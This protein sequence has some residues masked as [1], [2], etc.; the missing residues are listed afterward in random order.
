MVNKKIDKTIFLLLMRIIMFWVLCINISIA[1]IST[2]FH[3][4]GHAYMAWS[5]GDNSVSRLLTLDPRVNVNIKT[6]ILGEL[7]N[8]F[9]INIPP[10]TYGQI[11]CNIDNLRN[12]RYGILYVSLAGPLINLFLA[13]L[14]TSIKMRYLLFAFGT[15]NW[16]IHYTIKSFI[17]FNI[18]A[19]IINMLPLPGFDG[20][21]FV[22]HINPD[23]ARWMKTYH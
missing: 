10:L 14:F 21:A 2:A 19:F 6:V 16:I 4:W 7:S 3:E 1:M 8:Y 22:A 17:R 5:L 11:K 9:G 13:C 18:L 12:R 23:L 20:F 15:T